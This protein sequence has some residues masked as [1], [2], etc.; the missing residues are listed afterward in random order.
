MRVLF[1]TNVILDALLAR[2]P[3][4]AEATALMAMVERKVIDGLLG[5]TTITT[6]YYLLARAAGDPIASAR[7]TS[8]LNL[9]DVAAVNQ[10]VLQSALQ[11]LFKDYE[12]AVLHEAARLA[13]ADAIVT[14]NV[15]DFRRATL[16]TY[17]PMELLAVLSVS[18][19]E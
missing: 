5:A 11:S 2:P 8:L 9:F 14:R 6:L 17:Q 3:F 7:I 4:V 13:R 19:R 16:S 15:R 1:D 10:S 18:K 12:D